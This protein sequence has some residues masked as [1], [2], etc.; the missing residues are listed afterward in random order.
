[1]DLAS[2]GAGTE[3]AGAG[4]WNAPE[5]AGGGDTDVCDDAVADT[6]PK[7]SLSFARVLGPTCPLPESFSLLIK[8][9]F[10]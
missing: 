3:D 9:Y 6:V 1:M 8:P 5:V 10:S 7:S 4:D 2:D